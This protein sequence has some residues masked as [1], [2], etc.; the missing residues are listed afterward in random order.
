[1]QFG[2]SVVGPATPGGNG[3]VLSANGITVKNFTI[4]DAGTGIATDANFSGDHIVHNTFINDV[5][6]VNPNTTSLST[7]KM[8]TITGN[9]FINDGATIINDII[10]HTSPRNLLIT[11]NTFA[12]AATDAI[13]RLD[14]LTQ[15][16]NVQITGNTMTGQ[17][18]EGV[19][20][21]NVTKAKINGNSI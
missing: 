20:I 8:T 4:R 11:N 10:S 3:F 9:R 19:V 21:A 14:G 5:F 6:G 13:I 7:A 2:A 15:S 18:H 1:G 17:A 12:N 16:V